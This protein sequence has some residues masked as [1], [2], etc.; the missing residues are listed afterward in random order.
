MGNQFASSQRVIALCDVCGFQYKLRELKNLIVKGRDTNVKACRECWNPDQPQLRLGEFPVNDPQAIRDPR[1][2]Q[3][4]GPSG[5]FSSRNIQWGWNPV[6]LNDPFNLVKD[7]RLIGVG[8][9]GQV[10]VTTS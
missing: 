5:D 10:T 9:I 6:G 7:N 2:D 3:S 4:L 8:Q 1:P